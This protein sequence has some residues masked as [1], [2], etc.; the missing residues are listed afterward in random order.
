M[1]RSRIDEIEKPSTAI[2]LSEE[3]SGVG[4]SFWRLYPLKTRFNGAFFIAT[5]PEN[6]AT[7]TA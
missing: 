7:I 6:P 2:K 4:L 1:V 5:F 3:K